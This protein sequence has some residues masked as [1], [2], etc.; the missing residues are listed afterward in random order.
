MC[1]CMCVYT[2]TYTQLVLKYYSLNQTDTNRFE[3][4]NKTSSSSFLTSVLEVLTSQ[5]DMQNVKS[6]TLYSYIFCIL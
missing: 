1:V 5:Q 2:H 4:M 6:V 3:L